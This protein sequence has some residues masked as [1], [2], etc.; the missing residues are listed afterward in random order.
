VF[1]T[2]TMQVGRVYDAACTL[3]AQRDPRVGVEDV[4]IPIVA[5]CDDSGLSDPRVA[6]VSDD[7]VARAWAAAEAGAAGSLTA[8]EEGAVGAGTGMECLGWKGG[9]GTA[10]RVLPDGHTL[11]AVVL[12]NFGTGDRLTVAGVPVGTLLPREHVSREAMRR[13]AAGSCIVVL[14]TDAPVDAHGCERIAR[15]AGLGLAR[16]GSVGHHGSGEIFLAL[17]TGL[18]GDRTAPAAGV[19]ISGRGLDPYF[20]AAVEATE[21][22]VVTTLLAATTTTGRG[23]R[24]VPALPLDRVAALVA[25]R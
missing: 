8:P 1:L 3:L 11:G 9:I 12:A 10:S 5:E 19:P 22:A 20:A 17:A 25:G 13:G 24:S 4:V 2:S 15:R 16:T 7:D 21:E 23:G 18:R 6:R 14:V